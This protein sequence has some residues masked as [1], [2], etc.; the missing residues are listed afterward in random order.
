[1]SDA[2]NVVI[3][4]AYNEESRI[5]A[6]IRRAASAAPDVDVVVIND[7][8]S[9][10]TADA[11]RDAGAVVLSHPFNMGYGVSLQ[12]GYKYALNHDYGAV[13][14]M[15]ADGQHDPVYI[16]QML[17]A[18]RVQKA[19]MVIGSR[20]TVKTGYK[21]TVVRRLGSAFFALLATVITRS[22]ISDS[23]S[24][25]KA[26]TKDVLPLLASDAF[27]SDY[28][29]ADL[30]VLLHHSH[31]TIKEMPMEMKQ[32]DG[33]KSMH[34][35]FVKNVY[36]VFKMCLSIMLNLIRKPVAGYRRKPCH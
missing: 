30:L 6:I 5:S 31:F 11:A 15:D 28:P 34:Q 20:Y 2:K 22:R 24:G 21:S 27:P 32:S 19:D 9:D 14:Q 7:G 17:E 23:T 29:D 33:K 8:S 12:T 16:P 18:L 4:P 3:I 36:Y 1:M 35:G 25:Y 26:I 13:V 10:R